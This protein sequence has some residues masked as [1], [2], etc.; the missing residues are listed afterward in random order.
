MSHE[1][2]RY[3]VEDRV[4]TITIDR[5]ERRN[6]MTH[7]MNAEFGRLIREASNDDAV[8]VL[9]VT[10]AGGSFCAGTDLSDLDGQSPEERE[11]LSRRASRGSVGGRSHRARNPPCAPSTASPSAWARSSRAMRTSAS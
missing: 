7:A 8:H 10:G 2:I 1:N 5:P 11:G 4:A 6:A 9:V 3:D